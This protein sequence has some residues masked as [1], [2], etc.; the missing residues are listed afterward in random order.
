MTLRNRRNQGKKSVAGRFGLLALMM[1]LATLGACGQTGGPE[2]G[3]NPG[4]TKDEARAMGKADNG[5]D[6]CADNNWYGDGECDTFCP[7]PDPDCDDTTEPEPTV[8]G[9]D[10]EPDPEATLETY[11]FVV[12]LGPGMGANMRLVYQARSDS[13][14]CTDGGF[15]EGGSYRRVPEQYYDDIE[16]DGCS[17]DDNG[18]RICTY[19]FPNERGDNCDSVIRNIEVVPTDEA[20]TMEPWAS[21]SFVDRTEYDNSVQEVG[22]RIIHDTMNCGNDLYYYTPTGDATIRLSLAE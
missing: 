13:F 6:F 7:Q 9:Q 4:M 11:H 20:G 19:S 16:P 1:G 10:P 12:I 15:D 5:E 17:R 14:W 21:L 18:D 3:P 8:P 2:A 22:C